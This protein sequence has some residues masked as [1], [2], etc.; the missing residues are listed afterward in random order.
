MLSTAIATG[1]A[2]APWGAALPLALEADPVPSSAGTLGQ[3]VF[4]VLAVAGLAFF[5]CARRRFDWYSVAFLSAVAYFLPGFF[6]YALLPRSATRDDLEPVPL[7]EPVYFIMAAVLLALAAGAVLFDLLGLERSR[8][9]LRFQGSSWA[10]Y[11]ALG[12]GVLGLGLTV[13]TVGGALIGTE[14]SVLLGLLGRW[15]H[16]YVNAALIGLAFSWIERRRGLGLAFGAFLLFEL[17]LGFRFPLAIATIAIFCLWLAGQGRRRLVIERWRI[18]LA[19]LAAAWFF[20]FAKR[21]V[22][23]MRGGNWK[24]VIRKVTDPEQYLAAIVE[25]EPFKTLAILN[26]IIVRDVRVGLD[27][28]A[29]FQTSLL[30]MA[31]ELGLDVSSFGREVVGQQLFPDALAGVASNLWAEVWST[32]GWPLIATALLLWVLGLGALSVLLEARDPLVRAAA[33][34]LGSYWSFYLHRNDLLYQIT[35]SRR[36]VAVGVASLLIATVAWALMERRARGAPRRSHA[37]DP[38]P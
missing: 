21:L 16:L 36:V 27:H 33:A 15:R 23:P 12:L 24:L 18:G 29:D 9:R 37:P 14:K 30:W 34:I 11:A 22:A 10:G 6:G 7:V 25:S 13:A 20:F 8:V 5:L 4:L 31:P 1:P 28:L 3:V 26:E 19:G 35:L 32:G 17:Y 38:A 2:G